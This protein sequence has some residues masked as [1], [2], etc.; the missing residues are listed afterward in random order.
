ML[1]KFLEFNHPF[2]NRENKV[3]KSAK[4][5]NGVRAEQIRIVLIGSRISVFCCIC[6][7]G[8][9]REYSTK[10]THSNARPPFLI[11]VDGVFF[12]ASIHHS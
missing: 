9:F 8:Q 6:S 10:L 1:V 7:G 2:V 4:L 12:L 11:L 5:K 3:L